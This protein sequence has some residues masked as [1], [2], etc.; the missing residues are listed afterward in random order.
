VETPKAAPP[1]QTPV[2]PAFGRT[3]CL[4]LL[5][6]APA[7]I[8]SNA[9]H[10]IE[11]LRSIGGLPAHVAGAF[12]FP[13]GFQQADDGRY[14][15]FDRRAHAVYTIAGDDPPRKIIEVGQEKGRVLDP[16]AFDIDPADGSFAVADAPGAQERIQT[17]TAGGSQLG[18]FTLPGREVP[19][20]TLGNIV[21]N[22]IGSLQFTGRSVLLNKPERGVLVTELAFDGSLV[23]AFGQFRATGHE[24]DPDLHLA[25]N[26][27]L[28][29]IDPTGGYYF[30]FQAGIPLF[31]K[32]D[33]SGAL[34][35]E[36]HIEGP[37][38]DEYLRT[39]PTSWPRHRTEDGD[40]L[41]LVPPAITT[42]AVDRRGHLWV[43]L[44]SPFTYIYDPAGDK[45]R[46]VQFKGAGVLTPTSLFFTKSGRVLV[47][48][49]CYI[50]QP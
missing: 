28:P 26:A 24:S 22:G 20:L 38:V 46:T 41:P 36:R 2:A 7:V 5:L 16:S 49:G 8:H 40:M 25:F 29:L 1:P 34:L 4:V 17:F 45:I 14:F 43:S 9:Q 39:M 6:A 37:E 3:F 31:R 15:V 47:T 35:F 21:L 10:R 33:A 19:R 30:V 13:L 27:G 32:F 18:G 42:A 50:F 44:A 12:Q 48:P 23:R 11:V